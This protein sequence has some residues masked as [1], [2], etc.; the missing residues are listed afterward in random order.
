MSRI[1]H[2]IPTFRFVVTVDGAAYGVFTECELPTIEWETEPVKEGGLNSYTHALLGRRKAA[3]FTLKNGVGT[4][5]L[6]SWYMDTMNATFAEQGTG[7]RRVVTIELLDS[8][9]NPVMT[10]EIQNALPTKWSGPGLKTGENSIAIQ[11]FQL[12]CGE[13]TTIPAASS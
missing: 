10:W 12:S 1:T 7:L 8:L 6:V 5:D 2:E 13:I 3:T 4:G 9:K 11:T